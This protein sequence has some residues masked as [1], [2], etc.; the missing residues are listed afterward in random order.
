MARPRFTVSV[1]GSGIV[2]KLNAG[3]AS[4]ATV[5]TGKGLK[6]EI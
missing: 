6:A 4:H 1:V 2:L 5:D 3:A